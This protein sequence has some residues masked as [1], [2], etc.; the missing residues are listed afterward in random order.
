MR[1]D[2]KKAARELAEKLL[3]GADEKK[4]EAAAKTILEYLEEA[5]G[6]GLQ[7]F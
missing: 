3:K 7:Q 4:L 2:P 5:H 1:Y 6:A